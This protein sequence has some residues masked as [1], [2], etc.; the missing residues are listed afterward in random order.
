MITKGIFS[1]ASMKSQ[2]YMLHAWIGLE[3]DAGAE[4][5]NFNYFTITLQMQGCET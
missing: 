2:K 4:L 5:I 1:N 3:S